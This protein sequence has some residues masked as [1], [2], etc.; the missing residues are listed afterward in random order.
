MLQLAL[1][2][3][4]QAVGDTGAAAQNHALFV[5][6]RGVLGLLMQLAPLLPFRMYCGLAVIRPLAESTCSCD[7]QAHIL[8][9]HTTPKGVR[10]RHSPTLHS[11]FR[12]RWSL[13]PTQMAEW[14]WP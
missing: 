9:Q 10:T 4:Q 7:I 13:P 8:P 2:Q 1:R 12:C 6:V 11:V 14:L 5:P 3:V